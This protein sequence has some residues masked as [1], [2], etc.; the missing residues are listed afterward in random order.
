[1]RG[2]DTGGEEVKN[3][4]IASAQAGTKESKARAEESSNLIPQGA[5]LASSLRMQAYEPRAPG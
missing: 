3:S 5:N 4:K 1:M 2:G